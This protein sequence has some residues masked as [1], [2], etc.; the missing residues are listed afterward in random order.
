M[1][2]PAL[3]VAFARQEIEQGTES[4]T[5]FLAPLYHWSDDDGQGR[6]W[7]E[8]STIFSAHAEQLIGGILTVIERDPGLDDSRTRQLAGL[9]F[10]LNGWL[11]QPMTVTDMSLA[12]S[13]PLS[14]I[15][16]VRD[17]DDWLV[18]QHGALGSRLA[19]SLASASRLETRLGIGRIMVGVPFEHEQIVLDETAALLDPKVSPEL[20]AIAW[21][22]LYTTRPQQAE[23]VLPRLLELALRR[24]EL[25]IPVD[26]T[27][28]FTHAAFPADFPGYKSWIRVVASPGELRPSGAM[29]ELPEL[30]EENMT[31]QPGAN[32][33]PQP[34][35]LI[36]DF[37]SVPSLLGVRHRLPAN[38]CGTQQ[39]L[40]PGGGGT[41]GGWPASPLRAPADAS[42]DLTIMYLMM[43]YGVGENV[44]AGPV[45]DWL[46]SFIVPKHGVDLKGFDPIQPLNS[47]TAE[48][49]D[50][51][52]RLCLS[53]TAQ[54][55]KVMLWLDL[56]NWPE[57]ASNGTNHPG[58]M[59][60]FA[61][62]TPDN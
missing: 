12:A 3:R 38:I 5:A 45:I 52:V 37:G 48:Q 49:N 54:K 24:K 30:L 61:P 46:D 20:R 55:A 2:P 44:E 59:P 13:G 6:T 18:S 40:P 56:E 26:S 36:A 9:A 8:N 60:P 10:Q 33:P 47:I 1:A 17:R 19:D 53:Q 39:V 7:L 23:V 34:P 58:G 41:F 42:F 62:E 4:S 31:G 16:Q 57:T 32:Q 50:A 43:W 29:L 21:W 35:R 25:E 15:E 11:H 22:N 51:V 28:G 27:G 14:L